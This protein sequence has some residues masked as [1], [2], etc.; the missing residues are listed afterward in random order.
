[1][2]L[3]AVALAVFALT[4]CSLGAEGPRDVTAVLAP[5]RESHKLPAMAGAIVTGEGL[6]AVG[7]DG[8]RERGK[9]EKVT[10]D[11]Q[12]HLG[13]CTKSMTATLCAILVEERKLSFDTTVGEVFAGV[14]DMDPGWKDVTLRQLLT[15]HAGAPPSLDADGLWGRLWQHAGT[16]T[17]ARRMLVEGVLKHPPDPKPGTKFV[18][19][20]A[21]FSI[22][23]AMAETVMKEPYESLVTRRLFDPLGMK[24]AGFGAPGTKDA[25]DEPRG[26][27]VNG[28]PVEPGRDADNPAAI[29][30]AGRVHCTIG[31]WAK[32]VQLHLVGE[33]KDAAKVLTPES[34]A[35]LHAPVADGSKYAM[36]WVVDQRPWAGGRVLTHNGS[37]TMWFCVTWIA[38]ERDFAVLVTCNEGGDDAA[39]ACDEASAALIQDHLAHAKEHAK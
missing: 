23:G 25:V 16:P 34:F 28:G 20:N 6:E 17:E 9:P 4:V 36:G 12:W 21:G 29:A 10:V 35:T 32:Y 2:R 33:K 37:N 11:D 1:M 13:S 7:A 18:Y 14:K 38:P 24:S 39:K 5:I 19:S 8:V 31:D 3:P 22:A 26:H 15:N 30:P 27:R